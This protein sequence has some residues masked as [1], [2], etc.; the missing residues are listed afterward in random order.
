MRVPAFLFLGVSDMTIFLKVRGGD[1]YEIPFAPGWSRFGAM[2]FAL[3][4]IGV[5][6]ADLECFE[7]RDAR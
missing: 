6:R 2:R 1:A 3:G 5:R 7:V 4:L